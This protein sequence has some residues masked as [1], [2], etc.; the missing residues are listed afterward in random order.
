MK[1][2]Q[3]ITALNTYSNPHSFLA[4]FRFN[5]DNFYIGVYDF[6]GLIAKKLIIP[7]TS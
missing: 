4:I 2:Q 1:S 7:N 5:L 6:I 3:I